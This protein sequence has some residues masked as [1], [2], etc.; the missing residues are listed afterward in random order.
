MR[1]TIDGGKR[2]VRMWF[3]YDKLIS[4]ES[5]L[6]GW[7]VTLLWWLRSSF[8]I[9][10][11][12][13]GGINCTRSSVHGA[14]KGRRW[15]KTPKGIICS[16][17]KLCSEI[18]GVCR[19]LLSLRIATLGC[20]DNIILSHTS[21]IASG[22]ARILCCSLPARPLAHYANIFFTADIW[23]IA[24]RYLL[25]H[26][27]IFTLCL[28][29]TVIAPWRFVGRVCNGKALSLVLVNLWERYY[30]TGRLRKRQDIY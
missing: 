5:L 29:G 4:L 25:R 27:L 30:R 28:R 18:P 20:R 16:W 26:S 21:H 15:Q 9:F 3:P 22:S 23:K 13:Q 6:F 10:C 2:V 17:Q 19:V 8:D 1:D 24:Q 11:I 7:W 12:D 14:H